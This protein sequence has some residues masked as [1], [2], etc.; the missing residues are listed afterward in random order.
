MNQEEKMSRS[1]PPGYQDQTEDGGLKCG[2]FVA[3]GT[4]QPHFSIEWMQ[5]GRNARLKLD[6]WYGASVPTELPAGL[7]RI[8][9]LLAPHIGPFLNLC[10]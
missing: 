7:S 5:A 9:G 6:Y 3:K 1:N 2:F 8:D 10:P 4:R